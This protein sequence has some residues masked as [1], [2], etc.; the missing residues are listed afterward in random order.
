M[1]KK[2]SIMARFQEQKNIIQSSQCRKS[3][4]HPFII[5]TLNKLRIEENF[6]NPKKAVSEKHSAN[7]ILT[8]KDHRLSLLRSETRQGGP[9]E[10]LLFNMVIEFLARAISQENRRHQTRKEVKLSLFPEDM[11]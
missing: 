1:E 8:V 6:L 10:P 5:K 9:L 3:I 11:I 2:T 7:I 4:Q